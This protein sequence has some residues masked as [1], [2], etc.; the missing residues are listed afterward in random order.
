M[1]IDQGCTRTAPTPIFAALGSLNNSITTLEG[2]LEELKERLTPVRNENPQDFEGPR[3][4]DRSA[5][6]PAAAG[7][8]LECAIRETGGRIVSLERAFGSLLRSL[9]V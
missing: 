1:P 6:V 9:D 5:N 7:S 2:A 8:P 4:P 3:A